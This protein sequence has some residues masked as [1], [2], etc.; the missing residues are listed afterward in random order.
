MFDF[1]RRANRATFWAGNL[2]FF[3]IGA[4]VGFIEFIAPY[5]NVVSVV[6]GIISL[7]VIVFLVLF[8]ICLVRQRVN[9]IGIYVPV[10]T[11]LGIFTPVALIIGLV[12]G[13]NQKNRFGPQ[14]QKGIKLNLRN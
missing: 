13:Q 1:S 3:V 10:L 7:I 4:C 6:V 12:P 2:L 14:P 11:V 9:D 8:Y 5:N